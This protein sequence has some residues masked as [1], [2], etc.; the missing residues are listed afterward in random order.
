MN[1][2]LVTTT[3]ATA[4]IATATLS[5]AAIEASA[6]QEVKF[7]CGQSF[8]QSSGQRYPTTY[9]WNN[10]GKTQVIQWRRPWGTGVTPQQR[11]EQVSPRFQEAYTNGSLKFLTNG[12]LNGQPVICTAKEQGGQ[13]Q[14]VLMTLRPEDNSL[15]ILKQLQSVLGGRVTGPVVHSSGTAQAYYQVDIENFLRTAPVEQE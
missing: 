13:C 7:V 15:Q 6:N 5:I 12:T 3:I 11:C 4:A 14:T 10:R 2:K 8:D 1:W 9:A